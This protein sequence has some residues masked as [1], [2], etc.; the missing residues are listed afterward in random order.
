M[1]DKIS[2][3]P[4]DDLEDC[5]DENMTLQDIADIYNVSVSTVKRWM[6]HYKLANGARPRKKKVDMLPAPDLSDLICALDRAKEKLKT[7][8]TEHPRRGYLLDGRPVKAE[9]LIKAAGIN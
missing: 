5:K 7:R 1:P 6:R 4:R 9:D 8:L 3:P 2:M